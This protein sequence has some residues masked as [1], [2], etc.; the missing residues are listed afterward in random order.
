MH[1]APFRAVLLNPAAAPP[2]SIGSLL[3]P[4]PFCG[5][6]TDAG[7]GPARR[8]RC[9]ACPPKRTAGRPGRRPCSAL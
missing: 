7:C 2:L 3:A 6:P 5:F 9:W 1:V 4:R 8:G